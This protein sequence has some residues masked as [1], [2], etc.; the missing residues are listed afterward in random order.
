MSEI[1]LTTKLR[2]GLTLREPFWVASSHLTQPS[3]L[4][5]WREIA[6]AALTLKTATRI[7][8][9][10]PGKTP[11][12]KRPTIDVLP[13]YGRSYYSDGLKSD[14]LHTYEECQ[15]QL[16]EAKALLPD[17]KIGVSVLATIEENFE[18]LSSVTKSADFVELNLKYSMRISDSTEDY[19]RR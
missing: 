6:P 10:E 2:N 18:E 11:G 14:E 4:K 15:N 3:M 5:I 17:T 7:D 13:R 19:W 12:G 9:S 16:S 1:D 8:R